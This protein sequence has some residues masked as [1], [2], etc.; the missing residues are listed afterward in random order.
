MSAPD[1]R[2]WLAYA[3]LDLDAA[4]HTASTG[5][6]APQIGCY[7]AQQ[8]V[9]K[10]LKAILILL[11]IRFPFTHDL[12]ELRD[13]IPV[14]WDLKQQHPDLSE[15][16]QWAVEARYPGNWRDA[17]EADAHN[18]AAQARTVVESVLRDLEQHG[19]DA[20]GSR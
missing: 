12:D 5:H 3:D 2:R 11:Q 8:A 14:G 9:E 18:A 6:L 17:A 20:Q 1:A 16:S 19:F 15:L 4:E 10:A 7:H 13:L